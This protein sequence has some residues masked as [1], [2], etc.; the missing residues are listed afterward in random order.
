M[1]YIIR[2]PQFSYRSVVK[3]V[4]TLALEHP[5]FRMNARLAE[6][7]IADFTKDNTRVGQ[8]PRKAIMAQSINSRQYPSYSMT[9]L[10]SRPGVSSQAIEGFEIPESSPLVRQWR[11]EFEGSSNAE[12]AGTQERSKGPLRLRAP[13]NSPGDVDG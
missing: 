4:L 10:L 8:L 6:I 11:S 9:E 13:D 2:F 3:P 1:T 7:N 5:E 12:M